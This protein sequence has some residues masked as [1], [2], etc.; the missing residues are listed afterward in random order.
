MECFV[1]QPCLVDPLGCCIPGLQISVCGSS[2]GHSGDLTLDVQFESA[3]K[4]DH[5]GLGVYVS[6]VR[7]CINQK[8]LTPELL[9]EVGPGSNWK[10]TSVCLLAKEVLRPLCS[11]SILEEGEGPEDFFLVA[12]E[13]L[14]GQV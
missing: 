7:F 1:C 11:M 5:Q 3:T 14:Q 13:L 10:D 6:G 4:F 12:G 9:F 2:E 8:E